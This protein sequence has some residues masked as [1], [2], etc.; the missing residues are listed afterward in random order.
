MFAVGFTF[1]P[2]ALALDDAVGVD[3][4]GLGAD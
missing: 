4:V 2:F 3:T 1:F